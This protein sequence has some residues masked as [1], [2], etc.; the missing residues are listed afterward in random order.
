MSFCLQCGKPVA[1]SSYRYCSNQCQGDY[2]YS[3]YVHKWKQGEVNG[4]RGVNA[5]NISRH[6]RRY[7]FGKYCGACSL[8]GWDK[9]NQVTQETPLE[10]DHID[11]NSENNRE[12]NLRLLCPNCHSLTP[13]FRN[14]NKGKGRGW[15]RLKY[16]KA[17]FD[18]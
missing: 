15:R 3:Q 17:S 11:G 10:I 18:G 2:Q 1:R 14:L 4:S 8:C 13:N 9:K 16:L 7:L 5:K 12:V 6:I